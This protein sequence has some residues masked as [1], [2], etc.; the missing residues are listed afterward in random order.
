MSPAISQLLAIKVIE[1]VSQRRSRHAKLLRLL[2]ELLQ[3]GGVE[4]AANGCTRQAK[5][6]SLVPEPLTPRPLLLVGPAV[7]Q[8]VAIKVVEQTSHSRS[9]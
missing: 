3:S 2:V 9:G 1:H 6:L 5:L 8:L 4:H 7:P